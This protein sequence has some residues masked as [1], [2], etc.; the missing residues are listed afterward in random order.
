V[1]PRIQEKFSAMAGNVYLV[2]TLVR[3]FNVGKGK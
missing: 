3:L 1:S 2:N